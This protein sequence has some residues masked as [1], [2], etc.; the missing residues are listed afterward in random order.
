MKITALL[1]AVLIGFSSLAARPAHADGKSQ[2]AYG[3]VILVGIAFLVASWRMDHEDQPIGL[4]QKDEEQKPSLVFCAPP[5][6][7]EDGRWDPAAGIGISGA[8]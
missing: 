8:F 7:A 3:A 5:S 2:L 1:L 4:L 6:F